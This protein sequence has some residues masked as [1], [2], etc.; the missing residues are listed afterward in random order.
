MACHINVCMNY[1]GYLLNGMSREDRE[2][3]LEQ[4]LFA[5]ME[6]GA[7]CIEESRE[8]W[9]R[10][11]ELLR[12]CLGNETFPEDALRQVRRNIR[13]IAEGFSYSSAC[14]ALF[15][16]YVGAKELVLRLERKE[17]TY[18]RNVHGQ[19]PDNVYWLSPLQR[20]RVNLLLDA[21]ERQDFVAAIGQ[22]IERKP[23]DGVTENGGFISY[24]GGALEVY[25]ID[26]DSAAKRNFSIRRLE[27]LRNPH[28]AMFHLHALS[29]DLSLYAGPSSNEGSSDTTACLRAGLDLFDINHVVFTKLH[30][31][32]FNA[33]Y[34][35]TEWNVRS[36][37]GGVNVSH[38]EW[39]PIVDLGNYDY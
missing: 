17:H 35:G 39:V 22:E 26:S 19:T 18:R 23:K 20:L 1:I 31:R 2:K 37:S 9:A 38:L 21:F 8:V 29:E 28:V 11:V 33:D 12:G 16:A 27:F 6:S 4:K 32:R 25:A 24:F 13:H 3:K 30:G 7:D 15:E 36:G 14:L 10:D 34:Y 5:L